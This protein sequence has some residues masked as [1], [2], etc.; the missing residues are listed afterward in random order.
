[1]DEVISE[2]LEGK[3]VVSDLTKVGFQKLVENAGLNWMQYLANVQTIA[4]EDARK[5]YREKYGMGHELLIQ[6]LRKERME[7]ARSPSNIGRDVAALSTLEAALEGWQS[8]ID[9]IGVMQ[10]S[11]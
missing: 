8:D 2:A 4:F 7:L 5:R 6:E 10:L 11:I 1:M 9:V 3:R